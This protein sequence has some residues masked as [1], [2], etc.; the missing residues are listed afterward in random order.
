ML[1]TKD[2]IRNQYINLYSLSNK[3]IVIPIFQRFYSWEPEQVQ[4]ILNDLSNCVYDM[5]KDFYLLDFI[6][7]KED[8]VIKLA[9]GQQRLI[10]I[11]LLIKALKEMAF[12]NHIHIE[13]IDFFEVSYDN[14]VYQGIYKNNFLND[15]GSPFKKVYLYLKKFV[16]SNLEHIRDF[17]KILKNN[18]FIYF[19][20][21]EN[22]DVAFSIFVEINTG[23]KDLTKAE[24]MKTA[25]DQ[26]GEVYKKQINASTKI[27]HSAISAYYKLV[28]VGKKGNFDA[29]A[30]MTFIKNHIVTTE[31]AFLEFYNIV[32]RIK[33]VCNYSIYYIVKYIKRPQLMDILNIMA[34][35]GID[36]NK[37]K[38][39]LSEIMVPLCLLSIAMSLK[40][41]NPGGKITSLYEE[42]IKMIK[43]EDRPPHIKAYIIN[44]ISENYEICRINFEDFEDG[45]G[46]ADVSEKIK[47]AL[48]LIDVL[49]KNMSSDL[50]ME[51]I[52]LEHIYPKNHKDWD[53]KGRPLNEE[54]QN[55]LIN[56]IGNYLLLNETVNKRI[57]DKYITEKVVEYEKIIKRDLTLQTE[58]NTLDFDKFINQKGEYIKKRQKDIAQL[59]YDNF[60]LGMVIIKK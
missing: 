60:P 8:N 50:N 55:E 3:K 40:K 12:N 38:K 14:P 33:S 30:L 43:N 11:N 2:S 28:N 48:L 42:I 39:Y 13:D 31:E 52:N 18:I 16:E 17:V 20:E 23:G 53:E 10:T 22:P 49:I 47:E 29:N 54:E 56:N 15:V 36:V 59:I 19:K 45:I 4:E 34:I 24:I 44:F 58:I 9:D 35:K 32:E 37:N 1:I 26:F 51:C 5:D 41:A 25:I 7:Y 21:A 6:R 27:I 57:K 46:K